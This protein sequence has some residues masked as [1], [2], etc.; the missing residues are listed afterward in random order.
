MAVENDTS[1]EGFGTVSRVRGIA[2]EYLSLGA[3]VAGLVA[4]AV[5]LIYVFIDAFGLS[6]ATPEWL[7]AYFLTLILPFAGFC[8]YSVGD[9]RLTK[10]VALAL[11]GGLVG[12][13]VVFNA[14]ELVQPIPGMSWQVAYL[15]IVVVP[16][17]AVVTTAA[18]QSAIGGTGLGLLGRLLGGA[19][20]GTAVA[21]LW[22]VFETS[23]WF[24]VYTLGILP[25]VG[26]YAYA[27]RTENTTIGSAALPLGVIGVIAASVL[28]AVVSI[29]LP[30]GLI[31]IWSIGLPLAVAS[32]GLVH[33]RGHTNRVTGAVGGSTLLAAV[34]GL[35]LG[36]SALP[37]GSG[38]IVLSMTVATTAVFLTEVLTN[39]KGQLGVVLPG[40]LVGG[41]LAGA[42]LVQTLG[43]QTPDVWLT[44]QFVTEAP[45]RTP[46]EA[47]L[48]PAI[49]GST[50]IIAMV[51][52]LSFILGVGA[53]VFLEE[54]MPNGGVLGSVTRL[55][56]INIANLAAVPSVVYGLLGLGLF[57][58]LLGLGYGTG[59]TAAL[60][61]SLLI[62][63]ITVISSQEAVRAVP[64]ELK[65]GSYAMGAT[66]WQTVKN[67]VLPEAMPGILTGTILA[68]GRA[69]GETAPLI[70]IGAATTVFNP[71]SG[72]WSKF[73]AMPMQI[74]A[75]AGF[76]QEEFRYGVVAAG[77]VT[78]LIVLITM[79]GT[80]I[81]VRN[82]LE[83][84][85]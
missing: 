83:R 62:L 52:V 75:W 66:R 35:L 65:Q 18:S 7:L 28:H 84:D 4:L 14:I 70:M 63:P 38:V 42:V 50:I 78:L 15:F 12:T 67:I 76:P 21:I 47:G 72:V 44:T 41:V 3:S 51:A 16:T 10:R 74:Y 81:I 6:T 36:S 37:P 48:Y 77:V 32:A 11:G 19:A 8:L 53:A 71:P 61:L 33:S 17:L 54:Y 30:S 1:G 13:A 57:A 68:L 2:F 22:I 23:L 27:R 58:N 56:Q 59:V 73:S 31:F 80:A 46:E 49:V 45:S 5:L 29:S 9:R 79:N 64:D 85:H 20:L 69:I 25:A 40:L 34:V 55:L 39:D 82:R 60:T 43:I 24:M 26:T